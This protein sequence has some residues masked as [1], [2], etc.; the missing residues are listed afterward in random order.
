MEKQEKNIA[1]VDHKIA[2][3]FTKVT[4]KNGLTFYRPNDAMTMIHEEFVREIKQTLSSDKRL[5]SEGIKK[6]F[7]LTYRKNRVRCVADHRFNRFFYK[8]DIRNFFD[9]ISCK[10]MARVV[11]QI[12]KTFSEEKIYQLLKRYFFHQNGG[13]VIGANA[14]PFLAD[15]Y[16]FYKLDLP[17]M[18]L[19]DRY[20]VVY[21]RYV[22]DLI[23]SSE[24]SI[25]TKKRRKIRNIISSA[26]LEVNHQKSDVF[27]LQERKTAQFL[28]VGIEFGGRI[29]V[30]RG[31]K[32][33]I[34]GMLEKAESTVGYI[35]Y[36]IL[37]GQCALLVELYHTFPG[38]MSE[39]ERKLFERYSCLVKALK[40]KRLRDKKKMNFNSF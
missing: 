28:G 29:F 40:A 19:C 2:P 10:E 27:D 14:S 33:R 23:F 9:S 25:G 18:D 5:F 4:R 39:G 1:L 26:R 36:D 12:D 38:E 16:A 35:P 6:K 13:L 3:R 8:T 15:L 24:Q 7:I 34:R 32:R 37:H 11:S 31:I 22:D 17:L 20:G 21:T 30:P